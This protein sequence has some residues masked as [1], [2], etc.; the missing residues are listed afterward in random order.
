MDNKETQ[1]DMKRILILLTIVVL[2]SL[3]PLLFYYIKFK[4][5]EISNSPTDWADFSTYLS[6]TTGVLLSFFAVTF[7]LI[8][9]YFTTRI[10]KYI[11]IK[12]LEFNTKQKELELK[13]TY[14]QNKPYP[15]LDLAKLP[16]K[17][18]ITLQNMG[19]GTL[20]IRKIQIRYNEAEN[21][22]SFRHLF[23]SKLTDVNTECINI[24]MNTAPNHV[25]GPNTDK[26]LLK[27][28]PSADENEDFKNYQLMCRNILKDCEVLLEY[29][30]I[31][32]NKFEYK[33]EL[34]F[35]R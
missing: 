27:I 23:L 22:D 16:N 7:A 2:I 3:I 25:L 24:E 30:D 26:F 9:I 29:E 1:L 31:F 21:F 10:A 4:E 12:D 13:L 32:E 28:A 33:K 6:G 8:S 15:Y 34:S 18:S 14:S 19:L 11:Q 17:T 5:Y 35:L 20:I